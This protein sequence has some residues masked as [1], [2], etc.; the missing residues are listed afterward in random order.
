MDMLD[1]SQ[2][3]QDGVNFTM[4]FTM[5]HDLKLTNFSFL[6]FLIKSFCTMVDRG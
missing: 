3:I 1:D 4:L 5:A 6:E 2:P